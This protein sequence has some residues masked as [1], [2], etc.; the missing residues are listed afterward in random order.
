[1]ARNTEKK[2]EKKAKDVLNIDLVL[3]ASEKVVSMYTA[4]QMMMRSV[5]VSCLWRKIDYIRQNGRESY[6]KTSK[7]PYHEKYCL[8]ANTTRYTCKYGFVEYDQVP[9][10]SLD[11]VWWYAERDAQTVI[12]YLDKLSLLHSPNLNKDVIYNILRDPSFKHVGK[13]MYNIKQP[14]ITMPAGTKIIEQALH[15]KGLHRLGTFMLPVTKWDIPIRP[16]SLK[17][18]REHFPAITCKVDM[19][20]LYTALDEQGKNV[21]CVRLRCVNKFDPTNINAVGQLIYHDPYV[22][23]HPS[24]TVVKERYPMLVWKN[25]YMF[26]KPYE[27]YLA[28][29]KAESAKLLGVEK[30]VPGLPITEEVWLKAA[31]TC[32][33]RY[34]RERRI[35]Q[36][37]YYGAPDVG[38]S[39]AFNGTGCKFTPFDFGD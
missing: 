19:V 32:A 23:T 15:G 36:Q 17:E 35:L 37:Q 27:Y 8:R 21:L 20:F 14:V 28:E 13:L 39:S 26:E 7:L 12:R 6:P 10:K 25:H 22:I 34:Q 24:K 29:V 33:E 5:Y 1:M 2:T 16:E 31:D 38:R 4:M 9:F 30:Y 3:D 11:R 18:L